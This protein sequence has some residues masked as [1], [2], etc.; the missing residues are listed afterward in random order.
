MSEL[1]AHPTRFT[2]NAHP[3]PESV[4]GRK[5]AINVEYRH[6]GLWAVN[7]L[8]ELLGSDG[9]WTY[10]NRTSGA[11][12]EFVHTFD[13]AMRLARE[14]APTVQVNGRTAAECWAWE[15]QIRAG[16]GEKP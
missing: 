7:H 6:A 10:D 15:Q 11:Q 2:I 9:L 3:L 8:G 13:E 4:N 1:T 16:A 12:V 5:Y 14:A